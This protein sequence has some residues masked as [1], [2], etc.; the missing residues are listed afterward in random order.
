MTAWSATCS[1]S[2]RNSQGSC[3]GRSHEGY[4]IPVDGPVGKMLGHL[5][6]HPYRPVHM[7]FKVT[8]DGMAGRADQR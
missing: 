8:A 1:A 3:R 2:S 5:G 7:H 4:P 6:R